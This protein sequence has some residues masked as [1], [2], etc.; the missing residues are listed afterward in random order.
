MSL[1]IHIANDLPG[2]HIIH[3]TLQLIAANKGLEFT[4]V[5]LA[6]GSDLQITDDLSSD[7][8]LCSLFYQNLTSLNFKGIKQITSNSYFFI[9]KITPRI[10]LRL[11]SFWSIVFWSIMSL[12]LTNMVAIHM[13]WVCRKEK[14]SCIKTLFRAWLMSFCPPIPSLISYRQGGENHLSSSLM[15]SIPSM[16][17]RTKTVTMCWKHI[18]IIRYPNCFGTTT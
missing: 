9:Q 7:I 5:P 1:K 4:Y 3:Y 11:F 10:I 17:L 18:N 2:R 15:I 13:L 6:D 14:I 12:K 16:A 8:P